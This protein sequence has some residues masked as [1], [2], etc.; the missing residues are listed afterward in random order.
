MR[1]IS[2]VGYVL[3]ASASLAA[4]Q[5]LPDTL[6]KCSEEK[7]DSVRL[8]CYD[9]EI[10]ALK[11]AG[12]DARPSPEARFGVAGELLRKQQERERE[13]APEL[14][15]LESNV[16]KVTTRARGEYVVQLENGQVWE[17]TEMKSSVIVRK[18][19]KVKI[20]PGSLGSFWLENSAGR[21]T[22]VKRIR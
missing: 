1:W 20:V 8:A 9:R 17:Q 7:T 15:Q 19:D 10:E 21:R 3:G 14:E 22:R 12:E 13:N 4:A 5:T 11:K 2:A 6:Q 16:A 18:G